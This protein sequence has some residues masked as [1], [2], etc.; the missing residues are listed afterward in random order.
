MINRHLL[1]IRGFTLVE[2][3]IVLVIIGLVIGGVMVG[4][5]LV[6]SSTIRAQVSQL[7]SFDSAVSVFKS[8]YGYLPGD[9]PNPLTFGLSF[10]ATTQAYCNANNVNGDGIVQD[11]NGLYPAVWTNC[12]PSYFFIHLKDANL[13]NDLSGKFKA[14]VSGCGAGNSAQTI[15]CQF[16]A[17]KIGTGGFTATTMANTQL[18]YFMGITNRDTS[19]F[20]PYALTMS[21]TGPTVV[22]IDAYNLDVKMDDGTPLRGKIKSVIRPATADSVSNNCI[23]SVAANSYNVTKTTPSCNLMIESSGN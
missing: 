3:A 21:S 16:P 18:G 19:I 7:Q 12:E 8:R 1:H 15:D 5:D 13:I 9:I 20:N 22:P 4:R 23:T 11:R 2:L 10:D 6:S 14:A 17:A